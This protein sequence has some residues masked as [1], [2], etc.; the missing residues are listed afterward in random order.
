MAL[1]LKD[2]N[3]RKVALRHVSS[4][5]EIDQVIYLVELLKE[6]GVYKFYSQNRAARPLGSRGRKMPYD[7]LASRWRRFGRRFSTESSESSIRVWDSRKLRENGSGVLALLLELG[8]GH[9]KSY[10]GYYGTLSELAG[11][12]RDPA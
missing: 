8:N 4:C 10:C 2:P 7:K 3:G 11:L 5:A 1:F 12:R 6:T 9:N